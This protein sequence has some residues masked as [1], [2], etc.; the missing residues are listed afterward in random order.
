[1]EPMTYHEGAEKYYD[2]FGAKDDAPF[3]TELAR[4]HGSKALELGVGTAR[5]AIQL[6]RSGVEAWGIDNSPHMLKAAEASLA[7]ES[8]EVQGRVHLRLADVRDFDLGEGFG[9]V[10]FPSYSFDH[11]LDRGD[12]LRALRAIRR[13]VAPGGVYAFDLAY[14]PEPRAESGWFVERRPLD[15]RRTVVRTGFHRTDPERRLMSV[16]L[17]YELYRNGRMLERYHEGGEVYV[18]SPEGI[19]GLLEE[20]GF[21]I[22]A[23]YGGHEKQPFDE[24][25][26]IMVIVARPA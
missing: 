8:P 17:W 22:E 19:R 26:N 18:H 3:Y 14:V 13:H 5:L 1:M 6:A 7:R 16:D 24:K 9:L 21:E 4:Q 23:W 12:Q 20:V 2:L 15:E 10:Y 25:R 11:L